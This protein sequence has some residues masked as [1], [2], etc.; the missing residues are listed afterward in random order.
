MYILN[1]ASDL[2]SKA[3]RP[4]RQEFNQICASNGGGWCWRT[5]E[6]SSSFFNCLLL[7]GVYAEIDCLAELESIKQKSKL[8]GN[9]FSWDGESQSQDLAFL[10]EVALRQHALI[11]SHIDNKSDAIAFRQ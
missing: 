7:V 6:V 8:S 9:E 10:W 11:E 1:R 3:T 2:V 4:H 5:S